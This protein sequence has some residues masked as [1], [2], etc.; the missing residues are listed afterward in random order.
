M[1][2]KTCGIGA[3]LAVGL[4][5]TLAGPAQAATT[6]AAGAP[7]EATIYVPSDFVAGL[8]DTRATGHYEVAGTGLHI[9]TEGAT[10]TDK[11]AEYV[12]TDIPLADVGEPSLD[13][14]ATDGATPPGFQLVVDFDGDGVADGILVG[15]TVYGNDW[16]L[17]NGAAKFAK[18][19]APSHETG[20]GSSNHGT[21]DQWRAVFP[22]A[23]VQAFGFSLGSGVLG[24]GVL[25]AINFAG[26]HYTFAHILDGKNECKAGGWATSTL[27]VF[28]NQGD[29]VSY[30]ATKK[31]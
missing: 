5:L 4:A 10:G 22:E 23:E 20:S 7:A 12:A 18:D 16:W 15:E 31:D 29:C 8:S 3:V 11:V 14:T 9:W 19:A 13:Y 6:D 30:F 27:P 2:K 25:N 28:R 24:D 21:L 1:L 17:S 26:T